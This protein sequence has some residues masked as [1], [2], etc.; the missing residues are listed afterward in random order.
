[1]DKKRISIV[2]DERLI[3]EDI[4]RTL[5]GL[6][7]SVVSISASGKD[8][9]KNV[10]K[11]RPDLILMDVVLKGEMNGIEAAHKIRKKYGTPV[12]YITA[13]ADKKTLE[14]AKVTEPFGY[15]LKPFEDRELHSTIEMALYKSKMEKRMKHLNAVL[16]AIR[17]VNFLIT[18]ENDRNEFIEGVCKSLIK[19]RGYYSAWI[20]TLDEGERIITTAEAGLG[21]NFSWIMKKMMNRNGT[22]CS[23]TALSQSDIVLIVDPKIT[24]QDCPIS[25]KLG[26]RCAMSVRLEHENKIYGLL[27]VSMPKSFIGLPEEH[28]LFKDVAKDIAYALHHMELEH[29]RRKIEAELKESERRFRTIFDNAT[30]GILLWDNR[31][32]SINMG[33]NMICQ[34][35]GY[36]PEELKNLTLADIYLQQNLTT[37]PPQKDTKLRK[38]KS[39]QNVP[40]IRKNDTVFYADISISR[41]SLAGKKYILGIFRDT[42]ERKKMEEKLRKSEE[43]YRGLADQLPQTVFEVDLEANVIFANRCAFKTFGYS[44]ED[45]DNGINAIEMFIPEERERV[46]ENIQKMLNG[47]NVVD[48]EFIALRKDGSTFPIAIYPAPILQ[49]DTPI[50]IRGIVIDLTA[51]KQAEE[52]LIES[53][54]KYRDFFENANDLIQSVDMDGKFIYVNQKWL[55]VMGYTQDEVKELDLKDILHK[56]QIPHCMELFKK[57]TDGNSL[58]HIETIFISKNGR[59]IPVEGN[60]NAQFEDGQF[61]ATRAIFRDISGRK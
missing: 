26:D 38:Y 59:E 40:I 37:I 4:K 18:R 30:D 61:I 16:R 53:E 60:V 51:Q 50:G 9:L 15:L 6:G 28:K 17:D 20:V 12:V 29:D 25:N 23:R 7:Y 19:T 33:N 14:K 44:Q 34:M 58:D 57:V 8:A 43:K 10:D 24:C 32:E 52:A 49:G 1:M 21:Q 41:I 11:Y 5:K 54:L 55:E 56:D 36:K 13:Y 48:S 31:S 22:P 46:L 27:T 35:L 3:A 45:L 2:E 42:T 47:E 39:A